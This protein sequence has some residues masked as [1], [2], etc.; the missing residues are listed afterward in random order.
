MVQVFEYYEDKDWYYLVMEY[1]A[2]KDI[3]SM[4]GHSNRF[5]ERDAC[6]IMRQILCIVIYLHS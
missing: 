5:T 1:L 3:I 4:I 6:E 2:G